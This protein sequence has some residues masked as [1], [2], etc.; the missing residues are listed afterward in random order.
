MSNRWLEIRAWTL[1]NTH[2]TKIASLL[3]THSSYERIQ[4]QQLQ[5]LTNKMQFR[6]A[7]ILSSLSSL[8]LRDTCILPSFISPL[9]Q[10]NYSI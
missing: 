3:L 7:M 8:S 1:P 9:L 2:P 10:Y 4:Q 6:F 5:L